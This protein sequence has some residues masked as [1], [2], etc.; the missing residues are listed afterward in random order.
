MQTCLPQNTSV[1][2]PNRLCLY[3][4]IFDLIFFA[5]AP[6]KQNSVKGQCFDHSASKIQ[7]V[8]SHLQFNTDALHSDNFILFTSAKAVL[9]RRPKNTFTKNNVPCVLLSLMLTRPF[10]NGCCLVGVCFLG[11]MH[12]SSSSSV[13]CSHL[14]PT[15]FNSPTPCIG[16]WLTSVKFGCKV[17][18]HWFN[19]LFGPIM[20]SHILQPRK[21]L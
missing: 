9:D 5:D 12:S 15:A 18:V 20:T 4:K 14:S 21:W 7:C 2:T 1:R 10:L 8:N 11:F 19:K 3:F 17:D 16:R 13:S 6:P